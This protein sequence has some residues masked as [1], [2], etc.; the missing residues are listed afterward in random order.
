MAQGLTLD[1]QAPSY[2][3][4][5]CQALA[6]VDARWGNLVKAYPDR[7]LRTRGDPYETLARSLVGQQISVKA[8]QAVWDRLMALLGHL[9]PDHLLGFTD[10]AL[11]GVGL[12]GQKVKYLRALSE[13]KL[14]NELELEYLES[15]DDQQTLEHL[16]QIK[17][18]GPWTA[19]MFLIFGLL[20][21][22][23]WP[24]DDLGVRK[25]ISLQFR[26]GAPVDR[27]EAI[28]FGETIRPWRTVASWYL[29]RS[30]DPVVIDY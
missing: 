14:S 20:R 21:P 10:D 24:V 11:R 12:S 9:S 15:L 26:D 25:G 3:E 22:D 30:L 28:Q 1:P 8:A 7:A 13:F 5:A 4:E 29:W 6:Q 2:W 27:S 16:C 18:I 17:G 19:Q 23:V